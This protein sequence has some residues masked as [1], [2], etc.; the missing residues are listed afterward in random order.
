[1]RFE[2]TPEFPARERAENMARPYNRRLSQS[3]AGAAWAARDPASELPPRLVG[4]APGPRYDTLVA[5]D[6]YQGLWEVDPL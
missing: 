3:Y 1:V 4:R 6:H 5:T 2:K